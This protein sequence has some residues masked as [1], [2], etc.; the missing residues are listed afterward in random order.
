MFLRVAAIL[1]GEGLLDE[2][3]LTGLSRRRLGGRLLEPQAA[4]VDAVRARIEKARTA[5]VAA[6]G[7]SYRRTPSE[8]NSRIDVVAAC[9]RSLAGAGNVAVRGRTPS[10]V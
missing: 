5:E 1:A 3:T 7:G 6:I 4:T 8:D 10:R 9:R 2:V